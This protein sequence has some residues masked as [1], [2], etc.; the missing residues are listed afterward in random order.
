MA[1]LKDP[2]MAVM[3][4][5]GTMSAMKNASRSSPVPKM[6][7]IRRVKPSEASFTAALSAA[8]MIAASEIR[9]LTDC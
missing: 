6:D 2:A 3:A 1:E 7:A 9:V 5:E 8:T 4:K